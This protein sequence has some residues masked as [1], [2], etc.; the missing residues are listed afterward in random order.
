[1]INAHLTGKLIKTD[2]INLEIK[3]FISHLVDPLYIFLWLVLFQIVFCGCLMY[4]KITFLCILYF[5]KN[6]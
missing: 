4:W 5:I 1:M 3:I 6:I 2:Q